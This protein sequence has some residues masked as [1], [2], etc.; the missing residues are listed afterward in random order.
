MAA[1]RYY[2]SDAISTFLKRNVNEIVGE[3]TL[4]SQHDI[5]DKTSQ[6]WVEEITTLQ[7]ILAPY[8]GHGSVYFEYN[9]PRMGRR[10]DVIAII[11]GVVFVLEYK[12]ANQEFERGAMVQVWDYALDLRIFKREASTAYSSPFL[13]FPKK[14]T[15]I[16]D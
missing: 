14:K 16:A 11:D 5:N 13:L 1:K 10:A 7:D 12:T 15:V 2:Y 9:I 3:L 6:S 8:S 4:A